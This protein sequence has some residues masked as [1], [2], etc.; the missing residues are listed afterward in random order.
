MIAS[1]ISIAI[2]AVVFLLG[3]QVNAPYQQI[4]GALSG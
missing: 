1:V 2:A 4:V 3:G